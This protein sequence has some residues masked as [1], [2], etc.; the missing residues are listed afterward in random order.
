MSPKVMYLASCAKI[1]DESPLDRLTTPKVVVCVYASNV[2]P[3]LLAN[4]LKYQVHGSERIG[5]LSVVTTHH[6]KALQDE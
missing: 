2:T 3:S 1:F 4:W 6:E 5:E